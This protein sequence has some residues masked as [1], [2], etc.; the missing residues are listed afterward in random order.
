MRLSIDG[1]EVARAPI[2]TTAP[3]M[4]NFSG[5]FTCGYHHMEPFD[6][7]YQPPFRFTGTIRRVGIVTSGT[8]PVD[9]TL[10]REVFLKRQ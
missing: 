3:V 8:Q 6:L 2:E 1:V 10:E 5:M 9:S 7:G 4:L